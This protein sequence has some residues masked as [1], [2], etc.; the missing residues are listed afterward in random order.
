VQPAVAALDQRRRL[1][2]PER[3]HARSSALLAIEEDGIE[4]LAVTPAEDA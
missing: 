2:R 4:S 1:D 3:P